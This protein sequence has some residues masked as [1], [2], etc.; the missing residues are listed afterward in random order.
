MLM[1]VATFFTMYPGEGAP[2][3]RSV[4]MF[5]LVIL[6]AVTST[7]SIFALPDASSKAMELWERAGASVRAGKD[8]L[9]VRRD[10]DMSVFKGD[11]VDRS[12]SL[13]ITMTKDAQGVWKAFVDPASLP[14]EKPPTSMDPLSIV[15]SD[16]DSVFDASLVSLGLTGR[17][18][19]IRA[20]QYEEASFVA[21]GVSGTVL[22]ALDGVSGLIV[23]ARWD[24][25]GDI[26]ARDIFVVY[27]PDGSGGFRPE[28]SRI[29]LERKLALIF[30]RTVRVSIQ[31]SDYTY[32]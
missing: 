4:F 18:D 15:G 27:G 28:S 10:V 9:A 30:T 3:M 29:E 31:Y 8:A 24:K 26:P 23:R 32:R 12:F 20:V 6:I 16:P 1:H 5:P 2:A 22:F 19:T 25:K 11:A 7:N 17:K 13:A 21:K 14:S